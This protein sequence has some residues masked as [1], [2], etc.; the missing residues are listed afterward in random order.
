M[1]IMDDL[2]LHEFVMLL[3]DLKATLTGD[4]RH[5]FAQCCKFDQEPGFSR[6]LCHQVTGSNTDSAYNRY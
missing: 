1:Q 3:K 2:F 4:G 6:V 5:V